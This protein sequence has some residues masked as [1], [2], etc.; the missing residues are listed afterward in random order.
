M[1]SLKVFLIN[2]VAILMML[3][4]LA[5]PGLFKIMVFQSKGYGVIISVHDVTDKVFSR[6]SNYIVDLLM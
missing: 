4:N 6:D 2:M 5:T 1:E 3:S